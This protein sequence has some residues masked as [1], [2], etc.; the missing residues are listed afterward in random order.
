MFGIK[1]EWEI[2]KTGNRSD[3]VTIAIVTTI[4]ILVVALNIILIFRMSANQSEELGQLQMENIR[5]ELQDTIENA[6]RMTL[7]VAVRAEQLLSSG[8]SQDTI[9]NFF[10]NEQREQKVLSNGECFNVYVAKND[11]IVLPEGKLPDDYRAS[12][13]IWYKG[14]AQNP[15][16]VFITEPYVDAAGH[17][18]CFTLSIMLSDKS[19]VIALDFNFDNANKSIKKLDTGNDRTALVVTKEGM[20]I[21]YR[22]D[23]FIGKN[24]KDYLPE[25]QRILVTILNANAHDSF[26]TEIEGRSKTVFFSRTLNGWYMILSV[27]DTS[28]YRSEYRH[29]MANSLINIIMI[30]V[31]VFY[32]FRSMKNR[33][34]A[35]KALH[36]KEEFLQGLS[37]ELNTPLKNI[38]KL[39]SMGASGNYESPTELSAKIREAALKLSEMINNLISFST[40]VKG[41]NAGLKKKSERNLRLSGLRKTPQLRVIVILT[42]AIFF[43]IGISVYTNMGWGDTKMNRSVETY[44]HCLS[45]WIVE[46]KTV[47]NMFANFISEHP[48]VMNNYPEAVKF[49][50]SIA[51]KYPHISVCYLANPN[52][53]HRIIMNN[54]W[55]PPAEFNPETRQWYIET[56]NSEDGFGISA[57]YYDVRTGFYCVTFSQKVIGKNGEF[58]GIFAID[59]YL[60]RLIQILDESYKYEGYAFLVDKN[61]MIINHP[62]ADY[63]MTTQKMISV[64]ETEYKKVYEQGEELFMQDYSGNYMT[65]ISKK[66]EASGFTVVVA[67]KWYNIYGQVIYFALSF[68]L[69][70]IVCICLVIALINQL[71][72]WQTEVRKKL[73]DEAKKALSADQAKSQFLAQMS[74]EI[75]TP[76]N[77]VLGMNEMILRESNDEDI[78]EYAENISTAG[79]T[80]L[81]LINSILDFSRIVERKMEIIPVRYDILTLID[82][83]VNMISEKANQKKLSLITKID[84]NLP[85]TL[86]G[87]DMRIKQVI[88]N[89]L[90]NS[91]KYTNQ[92]SI[93]LTISGEFIDDENLILYVS[94]EDTGIGIREKDIEKL[95]QSFTR[96]DETKNKNIEG[97]GLGISIV[98]ELLKMMNSHLEVSSV[99]GKGSNFSFKLLQKIIDKSPIGVYGEHHSDRRIQRSDKKNRLA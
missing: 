14:A 55:Q 75:R 74:H 92:G 84:P 63:Q 80:L 2:L 73:K 33:L 64:S 16:K 50:D 11:W 37:K 1:D 41:S 72:N 12:E 7:R 57:P 47:L 26:K 22:D 52:K 53:E 78:R 59:F 81:N 66:N 87:D 6:E 31:I 20:I 45:D 88:T 62:H 96:L 5:S 13:R 58:L 71:V 70:Y 68:I 97:T 34:N 28:L 8:A 69:I 35:Q 25:Y 49:L 39:S 17:G 85:R 4:F 36:A 40:I 56:K 9:K 93:T 32:Y 54:G 61:G 21:G 46:Q 51:K 94:V 29:L 10:I 38:L 44:E 99:Y 65:C 24:L 19:T 98:K 79:K 15:G 76:I 60:D 95:F 91:V 48:E 42:I 27:D 77:A 90:T 30:L 3:F 86:Y 83:L 43:N 89:I 82:D 23:Y 67:D 18:L